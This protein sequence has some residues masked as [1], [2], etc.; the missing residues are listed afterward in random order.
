MTFWV[1]FL[2]VFVA[3]TAVDYVYAKYTIACAE[4]RIYPAMLWAAIIPL[5]TGFV[6]LQYKD[7]PLL[8]VPTSLGA[9]VGTWMALYRRS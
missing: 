5:L 9:A 6:V 2:L 3:F 1:Q 7:E 8:L 4:R